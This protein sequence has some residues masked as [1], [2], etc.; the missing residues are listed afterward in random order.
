MPVPD[1]PLKTEPK[2]NHT[3][4]ANPPNGDT[5][6]TETGTNKGDSSDSETELSSYEIARNRITHRR[7]QANEARNKS[8]LRSPILCVLGHVDTGKTKILDK[9]R[10]V[11]LSYMHPE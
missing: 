3:P 5:I 11:Y 6:V 2:D 4:A 7:E 9:V 8:K 1:S 10:G